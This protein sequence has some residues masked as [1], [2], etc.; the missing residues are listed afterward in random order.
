MFLLS[1]GR[2]RSFLGLTMANSVVIQPRSQGP[3][4]TSR[5]EERGPWERGRLLVTEVLMKAKSISLE[6]FSQ[7]AGQLRHFYR[8]LEPFAP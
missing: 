4:S 5:E 7:T 3:L 1:R 8:L 6:S 2:R